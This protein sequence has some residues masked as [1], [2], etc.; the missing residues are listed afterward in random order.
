MSAKQ[1]HSF[2]MLSVSLLLGLAGAIAALLLLSWLTEEVLEGETRHFD[3]ATR[4]AI[5]QFASPGLTTAMRGISFFGSTLF[6]SVMTVVVI[7]CFVVRH[8]R[9]EAVLFAITMVGAALLDVTLKDTFHRSRPVPFFNIVA[10]SSYSFPSGHALASFCFYGALA[11]ILTARLKN[12]RSRTAIWGSA[13]IVVLLI[14]L[15]RIYLGVHYTTDVLAGFVAALIWIFV[16]TFVEQQLSKRR[17]R[18]R[19]VEQ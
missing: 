13:A 8:W 16:V 6:L 7:F 1:R 18:K 2:Q 15:S 12:T 4:L 17:Q 5:H 9:R 3:D 19:R 10:P 11:A 14:G